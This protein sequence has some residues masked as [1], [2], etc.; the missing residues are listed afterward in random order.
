ML[1]GIILTTFPIKR[2]RSAGANPSCHKAKGRAKPG[3]V[4]TWYKTHFLI[5]WMK[6]IKWNFTVLQCDIYLIL[7]KLLLWRHHT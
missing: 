6:Q 5:H 4:D 3:Q 1:Y 7:Y 2:Q